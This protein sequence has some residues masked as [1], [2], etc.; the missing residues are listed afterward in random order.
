MASVRNLLLSL[1]IALS[2]L[3]SVLGFVIPHVDL[4]KRVYGGF[5][6]SQSASRHAVAVYKRISS[7]SATVCGGSLIS[8]EYL[9]TAATCVSGGNGAVA[10]ASTVTVGYGNLDRYAQEQ[11]VAT[12]IFVHPK[13]FDGKGG[14]NIQYNIAVIRIP[15]LEFTDTVHRIPIYAGPIDPHVK[16]LATGWGGA[17]NWTGKKTNLQGAVVTT[18]D[19]STCAKTDAAFTDQNGPQICT[20]VDLSPG[21]GICTGDFGSGLLIKYNNKYSLA[22]VAN[23]LSGG[24]DNSGCV[25]AGAV[26]HFTHV[27]YFIDFI[28]QSTGLAKTFLTVGSE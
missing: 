17:E 22:G 28:T 20:L 21:K 8:K 6:M 24:S 1:C 19:I 4:S 5:N 27:D 13:F 10:N 7:N 15:K 3:Q 12:N 2:L 14:S 11:V 9:I 23:W 16:V 26:Q 18:G 25:G